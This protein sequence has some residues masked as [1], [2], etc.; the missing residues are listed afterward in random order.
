MGPHR[1]IEFLG[2]QVARRLFILFALCALLPLLTVAAVAYRHVAKQLNEQAEQHLRQ[3]ASSAGMAV[4]QQI[5]SAESELRS[6]GSDLSAGVA[7][8]VSH[9]PLRHLTEVQLRLER[10]PV[11][12]AEPGLFAIPDSVRDHMERGGTYLSVHRS[13][14]VPELYLASWTRAGGEPAT[15]W[16]R[17][18]ADSVW[19]MATIYSAADSGRELCVLDATLRPLFCPTAPPPPTAAGEATERD[20]VENQNA[21]LWSRDG[22]RRRGSRWTIFLTGQFRAPS[23]VAVVS[24]PESAALQPLQGFRRVFLP[25]LLLSLLTVLFLSNRQIRRTTH[26]IEELTRG[27]RR[28]AGRDFEGRV[29]VRSGDEFEDLAASFNRMADDLQQ[30]F[31]TLE[32]LRG[33]D[34]IALRSGRIEEVLSGLPA[35]LE[36]VVPE[37]RVWVCVRDDLELS[38][39]TVFE[40]SRAA[41]LES[42]AT[43]LSQSELKSLADGWPHTTLTSGSWTLISCTETGRGREE[44]ARIVDVFPFIVG[45]LPAGYLARERAS[46]AALSDDQVA[47]LC[48]V[49]DQTAL[50]IWSV[51]RLLEVDALKDGALTALARAVDAS[52]PWTSGHSER[53]A[54]YAELLARAH[55]LDETTIG[56]LKSAALIHDLGKIGVPH[57][58]LNKAG[59]LTQEEFAAVRD[60]TTIGARIL[61]PIEAYRS[62]LPIVRNH[63]ERFDGSGY[64]DGLSGS[65]IPLLARL[66]AVADTFDA[67]TSDRPYRLGLTFDQALEE[68]GS[69]AGTQ[70]DP[71]LVET[72][73]RFARANPDALMEIRARGPKQV[74]LGGLVS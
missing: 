32:A 50:A 52:S 47:A 38:D 41:E 39:A 29:R 24:E 14:G 55:G 59:P 17:V 28:I 10:T 61:E 21:V 33:L 1:S 15:L 51:R 27:T 57:S 16:G 13:G 12:G 56:R 54:L 62:M 68:I 53:V 72:F 67:L 7:T 6:I 49:A 66:V 73:L 44:G 70:F 63:H 18:R 22:V 31:R 45:G 30:Q 48:Q 5:L 8:D 65:R 19:T 71:A 35:A 3:A 11:R 20:G 69:E 25:V 36:K 42:T 40:V 64:P 4:V 74:S 58:I 43:T 23:W 46:R 26:P 60:H 37:A 34:R 2:T 9:R